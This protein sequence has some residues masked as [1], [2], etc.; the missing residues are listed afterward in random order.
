MLRNIAFWIPVDP[1]HQKMVPKER[2]FTKLTIGSTGIQNGVH[3][4]PKCCATSRFGF[5][6]TQFSK[7]FLR[8]F[9]AEARTR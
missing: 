8:Q 9:E 4:N 6:W 7:N 5:L 3:R 1:N 2:V